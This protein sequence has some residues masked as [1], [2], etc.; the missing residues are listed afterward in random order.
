MMING[1]LTMNSSRRFM[2]FISDI[3]I[4]HLKSYKYSSSFKCHVDKC[5]A[6][7]FKEMQNIKVELINK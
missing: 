6:E 7:N 4:Y 3:A 1:V 5:V 2:N